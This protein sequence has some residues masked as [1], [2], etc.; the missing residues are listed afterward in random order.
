MYAPELE[1]LD[2]LLGGNL[3][4][5]I[6]AQLFPTKERFS[7][8]ILNLLSSRDV[9]LLDN[10]G[11][12]VPQWKWREFFV[13]GTILDQMEHFTLCVTAQDASKVS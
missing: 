4:L 8:G 1:T 5:P 3:R 6:V 2:Q 7:Q 10:E 9:I 12:E 13:E 11:G